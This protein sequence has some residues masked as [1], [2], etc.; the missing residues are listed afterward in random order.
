MI[1]VKKLFFILILLNIAFAARAVEAECRWAQTPPKIDGKLDDAAWKEAQVVENFTAAWLPENQRKPP[2]ATKA[3][4]LWDREYLY[5]AAEME[6]WDV[7]ANVTEQDGAIWTCDVFEMFF[8]PARDKPGYY[9]FEVNAANGKLD[10]FLPSRGSGGYNRH[11][12]DRDFHI[13]SAVVVRGTLN[14]WN[15]RDEGW[16][17]EGRIPWRDFLPTGGRPAPGETW[18]HSLCRYDYSA[19]LEKH[20]LSTNT[21]TASEAKA[22][23]HRYEDYVPLKFIGPGEG[24]ATKRMPWDTSRLAGSPEPPPPWRAAPAFRKLR[25]SFPI[26]IA[27]EPGKDSYLLVECNGYVP[28]RKARI[29]RILDDTGATDPGVLL[30]LDESVYDICFH[31]RF[32]ENGY[33][34]LG[35]NG[36]AGEGKDDFHTRVLRYTLDRGTGRIDAASRRTIIEWWSHGHNGA[37]L[38]FGR[39]GMLYVTSGDGGNNSDEWSS[40]QDLTRLLAKVLRVDPDH[41]TDGRAYGI[42]RDNPFLGVPGACPETWAYGFRNPWRMTLDRATGDLWVG[43]NGQDLWEY[44]R[45][46]RRGENYG[47]PIV[48]GSHDF[49]PHRTR[50]PTPITGPIV[51]HGHSEFRSLTGGIV[52]RGSKFPELAGRYVYGDYSTGQIW[53]ARQQDRKLTADECLA[54]TSFAITGFCETPRG[55]ILVV[56]H[57]GNAIWRL[58]PAPPKRSAPPF[59]RRL[60]ETGLFE[61]TASLKPQP[62]LVRYEVNA[63]GWHDGAACERYLALPGHERMEFT[64]QGGWNF[65]DGAAIAQTLTRDGR[66]LETRVL[67]R[68]QGE[69]SGYSYAWNSDQTDAALVPSTGETRGDG[70]RIPSQQECSLCHSRQA[71]FVLGVSTAQLNRDGQIERW[72]KQGLIRCNH[73]TIEENQWRAE[74]AKDKPSD[75]TFQ[76]RLDL[77]LPNAAQRPPALDSPLLPRPARSYP[78]LANPNDPR[79]PLDDRARAYL[80]ANCS[81]CHVRNGGGNSAM[82]LAANIADMEVIDATP[83]HGTFGIPDARLAAPG[84]PERSM[85]VYRPAVR[86]PGQMPPMGTL[87]AD[88]AGIALL[89]QWIA[90][91]K[92]SSQAA[93]SLKP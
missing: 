34:F 85:L 23:F 31:P 86:G 35:S 66:R 81:H 82:Q 52:Y 56:D 18:M 67:L 36:R 6:D 37:S 63:P 3:R 12:R 62:A 65:P 27:P 54:D 21:P 48:E 60:S 72:E 47:W 4:L 78:R 70:W 79:A 76:A 40:G 2:T 77:V 83:M 1:C 17:V 71:N 24:A 16:T 9:E 91:M 90:S 44:A 93:Q 11:A 74:L 45:I 53:G 46:V 49:H 88:G 5:F 87:K 20:S 73:A 32:A 64:D 55:D 89:S 33:I 69:W 59:P 19:G 26:M 42:P 57:T 38:T 30:D 50:G 25:T 22:D 61:D 80:H 10:M 68:Q 51:E 7:F 29:R 43:E 58:E 8:K 84:A 15:D 92:P 13:K 14:Q 41:P 39:D 28:L 75:A